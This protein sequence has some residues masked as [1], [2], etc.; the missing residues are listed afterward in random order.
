MQLFEFKGGS[1]DR[2]FETK[3]MES[4]S[5]AELHATQSEEVRAQKRYREWIDIG[6]SLTRLLLRFK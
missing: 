5:L 1:A 6:P 2:I 4:D 3:A